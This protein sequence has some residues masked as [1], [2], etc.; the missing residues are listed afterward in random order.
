MLLPAAIGLGLVALVALC[1][2]VTRRGLLRTIPVDGDRSRSRR[3]TTTQAVLITRAMGPLALAT[4]ASFAGI[5][6]LPL[7]KSPT[8]ARWW[9]TITVA[10]TCLLILWMIA[11]LIRLSRRFAHRLT[12]VDADSPDD[13]ELWLGGSFYINRADPSLLAAKRAG[14]G[15]TLNYGHPVG[16]VPAVPILIDLVIV[17][18]VCILV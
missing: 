8:A 6:V 7:V 3:L 5:L 16:R 15:V 9:L 14:V 12:P 2:R 11:D 1:A 18:G 17:I 10:V 13:D 4:S